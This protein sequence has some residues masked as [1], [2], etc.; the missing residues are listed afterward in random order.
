MEIK[1]YTT[2]A[3]FHFWQVVTKGDKEEVFHRFA[4][5]EE[6]DQLSE[7]FVAKFKRGIESGY[8]VPYKGDNPPYD[9]LYKHL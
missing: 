2:N 5:E 8:V 7:E 4:W 9:P 1:L 6:W 3:R